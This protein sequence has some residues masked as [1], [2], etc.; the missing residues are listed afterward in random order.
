MLQPTKG[1]YKNKKKFLE[2]EPEEKE[3][4][5]EE[6]SLQMDVDDLGKLIII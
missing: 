5:F 1:D 2:M 4:K 3:R 6:C